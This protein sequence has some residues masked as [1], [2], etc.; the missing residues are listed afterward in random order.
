MIDVLLIE[1]N[2]KEGKGS[3]C[4]Q[5]ILLKCSVARFC[6]VFNSRYH[7]VKVSFVT[8]F[9]MWLKRCFVPATSSY[10]TKS[11]ALAAW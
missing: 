4:Y 11:K 6:F 7:F 9:P 1:K 3:S 8:K 5:L 2:F 10:V